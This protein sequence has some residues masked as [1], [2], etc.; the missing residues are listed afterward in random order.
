MDPT[1][2]FENVVRASIY[3]DNKLTPHPCGVYFQDVP[4]DPI[5]KLA[6]I[7]YDLADHLE[8]F[9][10]DFLH[11]HVYDYFSSHD[12]IK[13]LVKHDP[14]WKLLEMP[15]VIKQLF[16]VNNQ[17]EVVL[18]VKPTSILELADCLALIRP[19]KKYLLDQYLADRTKIRSELYRQGEGGYS[20]KKGHAVAYS[21]VIVLQLHLIKAGIKLAS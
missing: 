14:D 2:I 8:C 4:T 7:P 6:A 9:K 10:V 5:T 18:K 19:Q 13:E 16:Q 3:G 11:N 15:S 1:K 21:M 17:V 12:E 20:F